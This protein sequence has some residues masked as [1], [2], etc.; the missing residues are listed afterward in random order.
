MIKD[1]RAMRTSSRAGKLSQL[2][3]REGIGGLFVTNLK[4]IRYLTGFSG[5]FAYVGVRKSDSKL[6]IA[7]DGRYAIQVVKELEY[8]SVE[9]DVYV[10]KVQNGLSFIKKHLAGIDSIGFEA[11]NVT[12]SMLQM[13]QKSF[14]PQKLV[15]AKPLIEE[16]RLI[17]D[18]GEVDRIHMAAYI[19]DQAFKK[20]L[21]KF[22]PG[23]KESDIAALLDYE[24]R[25]FGASGNS[26]ETILASGEN[27]A[28]PHA[29]PSDR[30]LSEG[31]LVVCDFGATFD[32]Y[33]SDMT[34]T[35]SV[36]RVRSKTLREIYAIVL[37]AQLAGLREVKPGATTT[38]VDKAS[39]DIIVNAGY[40][41]KF[42][43]ST[44]H[45][46]GLDIHELPYVA[47]RGAVKLEEG[48]VVTVEPGIYI[49]DLGGVRIEDTVVVT[50]DGNMPLTSSGKEI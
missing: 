48:M 11:T 21:P 40:G 36:G 31:D 5:S 49:K 30:V 18:L 34:R 1:L 25:R 29:K 28:L 9:A 20:V 42:T 22:K 14:E 17:K 41:D 10:G 4:S 6:A 38:K 8:N 24:I 35:I 37:E 45:G 23:A 39:R 27:G 33:A 13:L 15:P 19:A 7:T 43:H 3:E 50:T 44:G 47:S 12:Y 32:G 16:L 26:F 2:M 46:V